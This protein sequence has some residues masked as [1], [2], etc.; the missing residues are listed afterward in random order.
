MT[1]AAVALA[2]LFSLCLH[3]FSHALVAY[4]G[5]DTTVK[6][7]GY[8]TF[9]PVKYAH[10]ILSLAMPLV[11]LFL[12]G[13]GLPGGAVYIE[14]ERLRSRGWQSA[15][16]L[17]GPASNLTLAVV[18]SLP[19]LLGFRPSGE[20]WLWPA[21]SFFIVLQVSAVL[22]NLLPLPGTDGFGILAPWLSRST[23]ESADHLSSAGIWILFLILW[24]VPPANEGFW[25]IIYAV[26]GALGVPLHLSW[27]GYQAFKFWQH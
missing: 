11:F 21:Y 4:L 20:G 16:S 17:A 12:G 7:K 18:L 5:G 15:V 2:W 3:E 6:E 19:F 27:E 10:P 9:N 25:N 22:L 13:I 8:L 26:S 1:T 24:Y 14:R 23:R